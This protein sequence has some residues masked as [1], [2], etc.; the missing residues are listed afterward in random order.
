VRARVNDVSRRLAWSGNYVVFGQ[1]TPGDDILLEFPLVESSASY[2]VNA[3][4]K[5][6]QTYACAFR[7]STLVDISPRDEA[8]TSYPLYLRDHLKRAG[9]APIVEVPRFVA[10]QRIIYW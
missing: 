5:D 2:T 4:T 6:E 3:R 7:G 9:K 10:D 8:P 1:L